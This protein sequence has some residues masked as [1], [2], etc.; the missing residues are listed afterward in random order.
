MVKHLPDELWLDIFEMAVDDVDFFEPVLPTTFSE[1]TWFK[2]L[3]GVWT[4]RVPHEIVNNA[5]RRSMFTKKVRG[6]SF[7]SSP[8]LRTKSVF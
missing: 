2:N 3:L 1:S 4:L 6:T 7:C 5:Q 8:G